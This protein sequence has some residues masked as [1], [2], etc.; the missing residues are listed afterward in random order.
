VRVVRGAGRGC[1]GGG[2]GCCSAASMRPLLRCERAML[3]PL[4][5]LRTALKLV[6]ACCVLLRCRYSMGVSYIFVFE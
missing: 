4:Q 3:M 5:G 2:C 1:T 6:A